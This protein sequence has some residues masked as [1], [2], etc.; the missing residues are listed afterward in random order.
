MPVNELMAGR[1]GNGK[2]LYSV[3][4]IGWLLYRNKKWFDKTGKVRKIYTNI[5]LAPAFEKR[6]L[7]KGQNFLGYFESMH[8]VCLL[9]DVDFC[10]LYTSPSPRDR[11]RSRM[12]SS[13]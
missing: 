9:R 11:T 4:L 7:Y 6:F 3:K 12:P 1:P 2:S 13:A 10:L 8:Q 5:K